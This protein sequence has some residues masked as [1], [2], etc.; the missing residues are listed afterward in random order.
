MGWDYTKGATKGQI[1]KELVKEQPLRD[2]QTWSN[3][4][5][6]IV[7]AGYKIAVKVLAHKV[8]KSSLWAVREVTK[9]YP[10]GKV[11]VE[12]YI[13]LGLLGSKKDFGW[14]YNSYCEQEGPFYYDC[15]LEFLDMVPPVDESWREKVR[16]W[17][18]R[19]TRPL[20]VNK[21]YKLD[22]CKIEHVTITALEPKLLGRG[23]DIKVYRLTRDLIG[24]E[25]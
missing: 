9:K 17:H 24:E 25:K 1:V 2:A 3:A 19:Q 10:D 21:T 22:G 20:E 18:R 14:G 7:D 16:E 12:T 23:P 6:Q 8:V 15:P 11:E 13:Y 4:K 5:Q